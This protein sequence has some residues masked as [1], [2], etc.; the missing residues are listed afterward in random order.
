MKSWLSSFKNNKRVADGPDN[1]VST[2]SRRN[3]DTNSNR[4]TRSMFTR[5]PGSR[6][7]PEPAQQPAEGT[8]TKNNGWVTGSNGGRRY[9][10]VAKT[11]AKPVKK[12]SK[13]SVKRPAKTVAKRPVKATRAA[14]AAKPAKHPA[15]T[16]KS[17]KKI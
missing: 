4:T 5:K 11:A 9:K 10:K 16:A 17:T 1:P 14:K 6:I 13:A 3:G 15:N 7:V 12:A 2:D 8:N